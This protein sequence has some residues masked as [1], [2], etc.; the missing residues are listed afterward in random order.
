MREPQ[1]FYLA[2]SRTGANVLDVRTG[3]LRDEADARASA[4]VC[5]MDETIRDMLAEANRAYLEDD[6]ERCHALIVGACHL[7]RADF[8]ITS[9]RPVK[10]PGTRVQD[11]EHQIG[12]E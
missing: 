6:R 1:A 4:G 12:E 8:P 2:A 11:S 5:T 10:A 7:L 9:R 3:N